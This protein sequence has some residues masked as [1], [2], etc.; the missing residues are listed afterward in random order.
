M[1]PH[2]RWINC[3]ATGYLTGLIHSDSEKVAGRLCFFFASN[4]FFRIP[5][6]FLDTLSCNNPLIYQ[7]L[8]WLV[9]F[10]TLLKSQAFLGSQIFNERT[11]NNEQ[12]LRNNWAPEVCS[13]ESWVVMWR[14][15]IMTPATPMAIYKLGNASCRR[16]RS[17]NGLLTLSTW[18]SWGITIAA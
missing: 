5:L 9:T 2:K 6:V 18:F 17:C 8:I 1:V 14:L 16:P 12:I 13:F 4:I 3:G 10:F 15:W 7:D 11:G